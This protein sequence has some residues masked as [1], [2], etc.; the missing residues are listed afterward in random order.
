MP[1]YP[2]AIAYT[3]DCGEFLLLHCVEELLKRGIPAC[4]KWGATLLV[5]AVL[6]GEAPLCRLLLKHGASAHMS[7]NGR[8]CALTAAVMYCGDEFHSRDHI[9][10]TSRGLLDAFSEAVSDAWRVDYVDITRNWG[11]RYAPIRA[12]KCSHDTTEW[13]YFFVSQKNFIQRAVEEKALRDFLLNFISSSLDYS[14]KLAILRILL[15][16]GLYPLIE[17]ASIFTIT[18]FLEI[19]CQYMGVDFVR[20]QLSAGATITHR[21]RCLRI[22]LE[23]ADAEMVYMLLEAGDDPNLGGVVPKRTNHGINRKT[24]PWTDEKAQRYDQ[25]CAYV[26]TLASQRVPSLQLQCG[27]LVNVMGLF[28]ETRSFADAQVNAALLRG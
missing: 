19:S 17:T 7:A 24:Q 15:D 16:N 8:N 3:D 10:E 2:G 4:T 22:V 27:V 5:D 14:H 20:M 1:C 18:T 28:E 12:L 9:L 23:K 6:R 26:A 11:D 13:L 25:L 21:G